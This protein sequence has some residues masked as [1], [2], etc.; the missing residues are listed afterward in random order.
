MLKKEK[1]KKQIK[2]VLLY[3]FDKDEDIEKIIDCV[4][5]VRDKFYRDTRMDK[6]DIGSE[7]KVILLESI[8]NFNS[9]GE[10]NE[11]YK[12]L[13]YL[14]KVLYNRL[15]DRSN[16]ISFSEED[17][18]NNYNSNLESINVPIEIIDNDYMKDDFE[19]EITSEIELESF[20]KLLSKREKQVY[21]YIFIKDYT[22]DTVADM[23]G[24]T[25]QTV[26]IYKN[27]VLNKYKDFCL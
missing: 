11:L 22:Q 14:N 25:Q 20:Y 4:I 24:I 15:Q 8:Q 2:N 21:Y 5:K 1:Y 26:N 23:L 10:E 6:E 7:L 16:L 3:Y 13:N 9:W 19:D 12:F 18:N 17:S 27:R